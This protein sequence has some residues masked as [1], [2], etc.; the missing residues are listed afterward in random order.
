M[1]TMKFTLLLTMLSPVF[2][3]AQNEF[4]LKNVRA[5]QENITASLKT[6]QIAINWEAAQDPA[7]KGEKFTLMLQEIAGMILG[8]Q[9]TYPGGGEWPLIDWS[10][11]LSLSN[12]VHDQRQILETTHT[13]AQSDE[14]LAKICALIEGTVT[15]GT[16]AELWYE[17]WLLSL[18]KSSNANLKRL[19][20]L[21]TS[22]FGEDISR[23]TGATRTIDWNKWESAFNQSDN[24][25]KA[26]LLVCMT[27]LAL[28]K[29][30]FAKVT[31]LHLGVFNG[32]N[33][34]L[35]AIALHSG[36]RKLGAAVVA[37]WQDI[38]DNH[39]NPKMKALAQEAL[40][41]GV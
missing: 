17:D 24:L 39:A 8:R 9:W 6:N 23:K 2:L 10:K 28:R 1:K 3:N 32:T 38:A 16:E 26:L 18:A 40:D 29:E 4:N 21:T 22:S 5:T 12:L 35:K 33:D 41:R 25:G 13:V 31:E 27:D 37:K 34:N 36:T 30:E 19:V 20:F 14:E 11:V 15:M 7:I